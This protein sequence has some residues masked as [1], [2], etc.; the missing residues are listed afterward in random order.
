METQ[1]IFIE[2]YNRNN[3]IKHVHNNKIKGRENISNYLNEYFCKVEET[4]KIMGK[5]IK[6]LSLQWL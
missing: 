6:I 4:L 3:Y 2:K 1:L 5:K